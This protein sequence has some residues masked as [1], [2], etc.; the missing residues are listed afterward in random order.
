MVSEANS[1]IYCLDGLF[2][3]YGSLNYY[4]N[5]SNLTYFFNANNELVYELGSCAVSLRGSVD[6][7]INEFITQLIKIAG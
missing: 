3:F 7:E 5:C 4:L 2:S 6:N 1:L